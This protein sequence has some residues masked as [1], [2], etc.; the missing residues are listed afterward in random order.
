MIDLEYNLVG[1]L[2]SGI[3]PYAFIK[4]RGRIEI[5]LETVQQIIICTA[6]GDRF[7]QLPAADLFVF[8]PVAVGHATF[9]QDGRDGTRGGRAVLRSKHRL[10][11]RRALRLLHVIRAS[12]KFAGPLR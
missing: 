1:R 5:A 3:R 10:E 8:I 12:V 6:K 7:G 4:P 9:P 2:G 11:G